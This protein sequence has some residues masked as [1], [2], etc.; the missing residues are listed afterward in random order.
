MRWPNV[1]M[2]QGQ[3]RRRWINIIPALGQLPV[4]ADRLDD[5]LWVIWESLKSQIM[6][7]RGI[8]GGGE[9]MGGEERVGQI[10]GNA[11]WM[12]GGG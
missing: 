3:R 5:A 7:W 10:T 12:A 9:E 6:V 2:V 1:S 4:L 8:Y 11:V